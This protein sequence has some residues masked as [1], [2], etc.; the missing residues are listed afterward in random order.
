[1][2]TTVDEP[3]ILRPYRDV[4][5]PPGCCVWAG[6]SVSDHRMEMTIPG[7]QVDAMFCLCLDDSQ[8]VSFQKVAMRQLIP[9]H[10]D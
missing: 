6:A 4:S 8:G 5:M 2:Y 1:M 10:P 3:S 9:T 7:V